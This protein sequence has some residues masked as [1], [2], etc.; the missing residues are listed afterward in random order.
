M[1]F[2][3]DSIPQLFIAISEYYK[4]QALSQ[5]LCENPFYFFK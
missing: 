2:S 1:K 5:I 4:R 3:E